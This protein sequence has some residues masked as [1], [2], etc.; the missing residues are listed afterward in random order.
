MRLSRLPLRVR[1]VAGFSAATIVVLLAAGWFIYWR[2][3]DALDRDPA[4]ELVQAYLT[5]ESLAPAHRAPRR[6]PR[7]V[8][9]SRGPTPVATR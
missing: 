9:S 7:G 4:T 3:E 5:L 2:V 6:R 8:P 1:L